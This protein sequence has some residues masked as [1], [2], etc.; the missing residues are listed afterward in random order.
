FIFDDESGIV[1]NE[2]IRDLWSIR[3]VLWPS[4][5]SGR[6]T[7]ARPLVSLSVAVNYAIGGLDV[8]GYH[9]FNL[10]VHIAATL[11]LFGLV[12]QTLLLPRFGSRFTWQ[13]TGLAF[14][15]AAIWGLHPLQTESVTYV[16][17]RAESMVGLFYLLTMY[18][19]ARSEA[20]GRS[21]RWDTLAVLA[22]LAGMATKEVMATAPL[23]VGL[24]LWV[25]VYPDPRELLR[26]RGKLLAA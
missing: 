15:V 22:C 26:Q 4:D 6:T 23:V 24:Y 17:Q 11:T 16:I 19:V 25:F 21:R 3:E 14:A 10:A 18:C 5:T 9:I 20:A 2:S 13:A 8:R 12:R 1:D 7:D